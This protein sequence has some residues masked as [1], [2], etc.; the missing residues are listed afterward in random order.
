M[1][2]EKIITLVCVFTFCLSFCTGVK[3]GN[4]AESQGFFEEFRN[5]PREYTLMPF[6][7]WNDRLEEAEI[8]RQ[9]ADF[10]AHGVYGF[11]IHPRIGLPEDTGWMSPRLLSAMR[12]ALEEARRRGMSV[13]LYDEGMYPSGS[14]AGQVAAENPRFAARG[15]YM[16]ELPDAENGGAES[17]SDSEKEAELKRDLESKKEPLWDLVQVQKRPN[18]KWIAI[19]ERPSNGFIRGLHYIG[20]GTGKMRESQPAAGDILSPDAV[21]CYRRLVYER[22]FE[23]FGEFFGNTVVGIFTDEPSEL[24]RGAARGVVPGNVGAL[25]RVSERLGYDFTPYL[26]DL[27]FKDTPESETRRRAYYRALHQVLVE[28]YYQNLSE[29]CEKHGVALCGHPGNSDDLASEAVFQIPGQDIVWRYVEPGGKALYGAH[30]TNAKAASSAMTNFGR[31]RNMNE[32]Y[33]A[34]GHN[35][36]FEEVKWLANW[37]MIRGQNLLVPHAFYYSVRGPRLEERPPDVGPN[38]TWWNDGFKEYADACRRICWLNSG[39]PVIHVAVLTDGVAVP[40]SS[41]APLFENQLDFN[42]LEMS[43][44]L[45]DGVVD[46]E[47]LHLAGMTYR[48]VILPSMGDMTPAGF[49]ESELMRK[50]RESGRL[51]TWNPQNVKAYVERVRELVTGNEAD[52]SNSVDDTVRISGKN[53]KNLRLRQ[54]RIGD[55]E[56][57]MIFNEAAAGAEVSVTNMPNGSCFTLN[58][59]TG[60]AFCCENAENMTFSKFEMKVFAITIGK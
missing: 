19:Y 39:E 28:V 26:A 8:V 11:V 56:C 40:F 54:V 1:R 52:N 30:S 42:Y 34:Y 24:G 60:E 16:V 55:V 44:L 45:R 13:L 38:S 50:L 4:C 51:V 49:Y 20:E 46:E 23:E 29:W 27:W 48:A 43:Q 14:S 36:T 57:V 10:E 47:G 2:L 5:P 17:V 58:A 31:T 18:G 12:T 22:Y 32:L 41:V 21:A 3:N 9:I 15:F 35:L 7:F 6:W 37:V 33:G 53:A 25:R 59:E